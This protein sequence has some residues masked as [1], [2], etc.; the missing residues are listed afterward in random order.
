MGARNVFCCAALLSTLGLA[1]VAIALGGFPV[2]APVES[3]RR[4]GRHALVSASGAGGG[5]RRPAPSAAALVDPY[6]PHPDPFIVP[7]IVHFVFGLDPTFG[8]IKFGLI[9]YMAILGARMFIQPDAIQWHYKYAPGEENVYWGC[10]LPA[11]T[12]VPEEDVTHVHGKKLTMRVQHRADILRMQIMLNTGG[13]YLDSDVIAL[14]SFEDLRRSPLSMG[15]EGGEGMCNAVMVG[16]PNTTFIQRWW[17]EY[18]HF[19]PEA[20]AYHSVQLPR[21]LQRA[22]PGEV[23]V[24]QEKAFF[25]PSW[26]HLTAMYDGECPLACPR[27]V[28]CCDGR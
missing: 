1:L 13:M 2:W 10:A 26:I 9:H 4:A 3:L 6:A 27:A 19:N 21:E 7:N 5:K 18:A 11:L 24:L 12:L 22:H 8:H 14:K 28:P 23:A 25:Y 20:W 15:L 16:A 17:A